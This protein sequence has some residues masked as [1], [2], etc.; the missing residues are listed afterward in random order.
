M[1]IFISLKDTWGISISSKQ[2]GGGWR[3]RTKQTPATGIRKMG[4]EKN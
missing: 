4:R 2:I 3:G 1:G